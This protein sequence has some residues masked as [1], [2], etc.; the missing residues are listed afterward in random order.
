MAYSTFQKFSGV[1]TCRCCGRRTRAVGDEINSVTGSD[2]LC[3][4][5]WELAGLENANFDGCLTTESEIAFAKSAFEVVKEKTGKS[6]AAYFPE[7]AKAVGF[8]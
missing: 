5:C 2:G 7:L 1:Y 4:D 8:A 3:A 6:V